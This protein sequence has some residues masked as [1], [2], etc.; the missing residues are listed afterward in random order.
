M[1]PQTNGILDRGNESKSDYGAFAKECAMKTIAVLALLVLG[2][3][4]AVSAQVLFSSPLSV[5]TL[6]EGGLVAL[7]AVVGLV[8]ALIARR[9]KK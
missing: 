5:P 6:D 2:T 3:A 4:P 7:V 9:R 1:Q 8:G